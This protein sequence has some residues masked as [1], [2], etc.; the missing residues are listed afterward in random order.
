M[1]VS[2]TR[3]PRAAGGYLSTILVGDRTCVACC[4]RTLSRITPFLLYF[5][6]ELAV[7]IL[8]QARSTPGFK[9]QNP[10]TR[11]VEHFGG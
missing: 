8:T 11:G 7:A 10:P 9:A 1:S 5:A 4:R 3:R 2:S 6:C